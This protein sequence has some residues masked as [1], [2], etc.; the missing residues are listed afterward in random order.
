MAKLALI[1]T[2]TAVPGK[3]EDIH[4]LYREQLAPRAEADDAQEVVVWCDDHGD[5][6]TFHLFE[7][8]RTEAAFRDNAASPFFADYMATAG[9]L[10]AAKPEV[11]MAKPR[12]STGI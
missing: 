4:R 5:E 10:L 2:S 3:R 12:W 6:D 7:I 8:Y 1:I 11:R 9:P